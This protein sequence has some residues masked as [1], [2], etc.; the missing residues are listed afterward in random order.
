V[1]VALILLLATLLAEA[2]D[3]EFWLVK[4]LGK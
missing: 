4:F 3:H 1:V 2:L